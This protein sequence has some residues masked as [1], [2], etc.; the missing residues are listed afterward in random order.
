[1]K[2]TLDIG[3]KGLRIRK[4]ILDASGFQKENALDIHGLDH[5]VVILEEKMTAEEMVRAIHSLKDLASDLLVHLAKVC[6]PCEHC[7]TPCPCAQAEEQISVPEELLKQASIPKGA[8]LDIFA[9]NGCLTITAADAPDLRD[10]PPEMLDL[11]RQSG[12]C[13]DALEELMIE[14]AVIYGV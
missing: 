12:V 2:F 11:L 8:K 9:E 1:M 3:K 14:E 6:G 5:A 10:V 13:L 7:E 4:E